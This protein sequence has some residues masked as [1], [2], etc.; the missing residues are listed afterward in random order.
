MHEIQRIRTHEILVRNGIRRALF[1][2]PD[3]VTW[4]TGFAPPVQTGPSPF[5][6]GPSLAWYAD[7]GFT[8]IA[9]EGQPTP[10][11]DNL[12]VITY[13]G[14]TLDPGFAGPDN[15]AA[16]VSSIVGPANAGRVGLENGTL[17]LRLASLFPD[18]ETV[19]IDGWLAPLRAVKTNEE[20][21]ALKKAFALTDAGHA[22]ARKAIHAGMREIDLWEE[23]RSAIELA[24]GCRVALGNDCV[25]NTRMNNI[26]GWPEG[27]EIEAGD[28]VVVDLGA[29]VDGYWS[30]S[31]ATYYAGPVSARAVAA[32]QT[33]QNALDFAASLLRPGAVTGEID[34]M[35]RAFIARSGYPVYPHHTGHGVGT[36]PHELPRIVPGNPQQLEPGMVIMLEPGIYEPG[37]LAVRV[38]DAFLITETGAQRLTG[39]LT[40]ISV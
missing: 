20:L 36:A 6:G 5:L 21:A 25:V 28:S 8:L 12:S 40:E 22:A 17:P 37:E 14:Y 38:E 7:G 16:T 19:P 34:R 13:P 18:A 26:G 11:A 39:H 23:I 15:L 1:A 9:M 24:A 32:H 33:A 29:R 2:H 4:L 27:R 31:C 10:A 35:A 30:D 3:S